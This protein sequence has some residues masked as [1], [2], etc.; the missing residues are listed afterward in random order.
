MKKNTRTVA[1]TLLKS[2][3]QAF[4]LRSALTALLL[5][6]LVGAPAVLSA[7]HSPLQTGRMLLSGS[8]WFVHESGANGERIPAVVPGAVQADLEAAGKL[9]P[10]SPA[11]GDDRVKEVPFK[12]WVLSKKFPIPAQQAGRRFTL[13]FD[14]V[15][16][17]CEVRLNGIK[18]GEHR[19]AF[20]R[21]AVDATASVRPGQDNELEVVLLP[22]RLDD[23][24]R[25]RMELDPDYITS[26]HFCDYY[27]DVI[28]K[29][30][31]K[32]PTTWG[33]DW[34]P[35]FW[36]VGIWKDVW[37]ESGGPSRIEWVRVQT[38]LEEN[39]T[40]ATVSAQVEV[41]VPAAGRAVV[42]GKISG[43]GPEL[44][45]KKTFDLQE[46]S[47][48][49]E[50]TFKMEKPELWWPNGQGAQPLYLLE[51]SVE[52][53]KGKVSDTK[54]TRF[55]VREIRWAQ[56]EGA[57]DDFIHPYRLVVNGRPIRYYGANLGP[58]DYM[59]GRIGRR[60]HVIDLAAA[61]GMNWMRVW[62]GG[63]VLPE[64]ILN[65]CDELGILLSH[66]FPIANCRPREDAELV[67]N[68]GETITDIVRQIR[69]HPCI[70]EY[71]GG[72][73]MVWGKE[74]LAKDPHPVLHAVAKAVADEDN[75]RFLP[76]CPVSG[77][78]HGP[79]VGNPFRY[80]DW[81]NPVS[82]GISGLT[83][84]YGEFG[85]Q[86][87]ARLE[88]WQRETTPA[89]LR[90]FRS[91]DDP[92]LSRKKAKFAVFNHEVWLG[93]PYI[94]ATFGKALEL[95]DAL[96]AGQF[97]GAETLRYAM[98]SLR[99]MG[100][101]NGGFTSWN[102]TEPWSNLAG[103]FQVDYD[104]KT[105]MNYDFAKQ[106]I[107][108]LALS[109]RYDSLFYDP[110]EGVRASL[111]I[112]S[113]RPGPVKDL[114]WKWTARDR[115]GGILAQKNGVVSVV[116]SMEVLKLDDL[117]IAPDLRTRFGPVFV[118]LRLDDAAGRL[119]Y[120]R[121]HLFAVRGAP[122]AFGG[123]LRNRTE[124]RDDTGPMAE[125]LLA[126][127]KKDAMQN[128]ANADNFAAV[129]N[130][131]QE[132]VAES[133]IWMVHGKPQSRTPAS[134]INDGKYGT[135]WQAGFKGDYSFTIDFSQ[136]RN[137]G[138]FKFGWSRGFSCLADEKGRTFKSIRIELSQDS[139]NWTEV[140]SEANLFAVPG[141]D[142]RQTTEVHIPP[143]TAR[144]VRVTLEQGK[145][146]VIGSGNSPMPLLDEFE[147][148]AP[149]EGSSLT[150]PQIV[151]PDS[152]V[153]AMAR[154]VRRTRLEVVAAPVE[155]EDGWEAVNLT[156]SNPGLM[157]ALFCE[158]H[159]V[160]RQPLD[161]LIE[162][163]NCFVP[164]GESRTLIV[165]VRKKEKGPSLDKIGWRVTCWNADDVVIPPPQA[166][167]KSNEQK[168]ERIL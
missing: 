99:R 115:R 40:R 143:F 16:A 136:S 105:L 164:P 1:C 46:G 75:R 87:P 35:P 67:K 81:W 123:L 156:V 85:T 47:N 34:A 74:G 157:T 22:V 154:P 94:D 60:T 8:D 52:D 107:S 73:E 109:L 71:T 102:F 159:P 166:G 134:N 39:G 12:T 37:L 153:S 90:N 162:N 45:A 3:W 62:G 65:R 98:D 92:I 59:Y 139:T 146:N 119:L 78:R 141:F 122:D 160:G 142:P 150:S 19:G 33:W 7:E 126:L 77:A 13:V 11:L 113:D 133:R 43:H 148:Y 151:C 79:W 15:D 96:L 61:A 56:V 147:V 93:L 18:L 57:P 58:L 165:K 29:D 129:A 6:A 163:N 76:T 49:I 152:D 9:R 26:K 144:A 137:V 28:N 110:D 63:V 44:I 120:E 86:T 132:A 10:L 48:R 5:V 30:I 68:V 140:Y 125:S 55:G 167:L 149:K 24:S 106:A 82:D 25:K 14:G 88:V 70:A 121:L 127:W 103:S 155:A 38:E 97:L 17:D 84:R 66:E 128:P 161:L 2:A 168:H 101:K 41:R 91:I 36:P 145:D 114:R 135:L 83:Y 130:G 112:S 116:E 32:S 108:P 21:F 53:E 31:V 95:P 20:R 117:A 4:P 158:P 89:A 80:P 138:V 111:W 104:G 131:A 72:N 118:E 124:D 54:E 42:R 50:V 100:G 64:S 27:R 69:N 23:A 51:T